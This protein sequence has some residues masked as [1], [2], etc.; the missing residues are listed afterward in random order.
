MHL[1]TRQLHSKS[2]IYDLRHNSLCGVSGIGSWE[3]LI[4]NVGIKISLSYPIIGCLIISL[5]LFLAGNKTLLYLVYRFLIII[6]NLSIFFLYPSLKL[7]TVAMAMLY[8]FA[9]S[10]EKI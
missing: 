4:M 7:S 5:Y 6:T 9:L 10:K 3:K 1:Y 2:R 8:N